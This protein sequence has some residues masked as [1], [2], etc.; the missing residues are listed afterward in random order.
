[1][2]SEEQST[3]ANNANQQTQSAEETL[4]SPEITTQSKNTLERS[5]KYDREGA[6]WYVVY[7]I[8]QED[9]IKQQILKRAETMGV[10]DRIFDV[11][12]PKKT[13]TKVSRGKRTEKSVS[14]YKK[15]I[16]VNM[17]LDDETFRAVRNTPGV[18][19]LIERPLDQV[20]V[21]RL[22]GRKR[23]KFSDE[24][25]PEET[26]YKVDFSEGDEVRIEGGAFDGFTGQASSIDL[27]SG[28]VTVTISV[29]GRLTPVDLMIDQVY[30]HVEH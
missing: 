24:D 13:V 28:K 3:N 4:P 29:F 30:P 17:I 10:K 21:A 12:V 18:L 23:K 2:N 19:Y 14:H 27:S 7:T 26:E 9:K 15:Y 11:Y 8:G 20:E 5:T 6:A 16:F 22:F 25:T 1:M